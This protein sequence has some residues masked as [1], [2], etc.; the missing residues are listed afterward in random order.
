MPISVCSTVNAIREDIASVRKD[1]GYSLTSSSSC[2]RQSHCGPKAKS[3]VLLFNTTYRVIISLPAKKE[4]KKKKKERKNISAAMVRTIGL[5]SSVDLISL[6]HQWH[7]V[8][9]LTIRTE[10]SRRQT[11]RSEDC[12]RLLVADVTVLVNFLNLALFFPTCVFPAGVFSACVFLALIFRA[13]DDG[14][15]FDVFG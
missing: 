1:D 3:S 2:I 4:E 6:S 14:D 7:G 15:C 13:L 9:F 11:R 8:R 5:E 12:I 10:S